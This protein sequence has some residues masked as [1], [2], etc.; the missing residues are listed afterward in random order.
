MDEPD[1][2]PKKCINSQEFIGLIEQEWELNESLKRKED[3]AM[4]Q[5]KATL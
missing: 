4:K 3:K 2:D 1:Q 5:G